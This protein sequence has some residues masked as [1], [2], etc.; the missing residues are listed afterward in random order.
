[1]RLTRSMRR[2]DEFMLT[3]IL[4]TSQIDMT[5]PI[6][7]SELEIDLRRMDRLSH[8]GSPENANTHKVTVTPS[9]RT[10]SPGLHRFRFEIQYGK[11]EGD[12][13]TPIGEPI[14]YQSE[15]LPFLD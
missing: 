5:N 9:I 6:I 1:M 14:Y 11:K 2:D 4:D 12:E 8:D 10:Y 3:R 7:Q 13:F 15:T